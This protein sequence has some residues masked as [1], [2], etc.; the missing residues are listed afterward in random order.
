MGWKDEYPFEFIIN[1]TTVRDFGPDVDM[2]DNPY[3][4]DAIETD[5][6]ELVTMAKTRFTYIYNVQDHWEHQ[7]TLEEILPSGEAPVYPVCT[8]G[9]RGCP[10]DDC[11]GISRY[12]EMLNALADEKHPEHNTIKRQFGEREDVALFNIEE[13]NTSLR[14]Y[15]EEWDE[16]YSETGE[17]DEDL[18]DENDDAELDGVEDSEY[19]RLKH[20]KSPQDLL[21]DEREKQAMED[22]VDDALAETTSVEYQ[23][24]SRLVNLGHNEE[25]SKVMII[26][27]FSIERFYD[28]K[29]GTDHFD[30]RYEYNLGQ[31]PETPQEIPSLDYAVEVL[32]Q[33]IKG[34]PFAA[35]EYLHNDT[36]REAT[37][38]IVK[39]LKNF[40]DHQYCWAD[41]TSTPIWYALSAE[42]HLC[43]ELID[44]VIGFYGNGN[45]NETD[46]LYEQGQYLIGR[47]AQ[48]YPD[49]T[50][51]KVL[52]AMEKD[53]GNGSKDATYFLFDVFKFCNLDK[54]K[55]RLIALLKQDNISWHDTLAATIAHLQIKEGLP[56]L[57]EQ[58]K[59]LKAKKPEKSFWDNQ[60]IIEIEEAIQQL[61]KG[62]DLYP[63]IDM[64]L[65]LKRGTTWKEE[66]AN[67]EKHFYDNEHF[68]ED[69]VDLKTP[70]Y[71]DPYPEF[72]R[73]LTYQQPIIKENK[74]G[75]ND[76]C[77]CGSGKKYKKCCLDKDLREE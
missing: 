74:T 29:Y 35:I 38:A 62:E 31:L 5:L 52:A 71:F 63:D 55:D 22:W 67:A 57:K 23:T 46:W 9:E 15:S 25:K 1:E 64:P 44:P 50:V 76:P 20:L 26:E 32:D 39:A 37:V 4:R 8:G 14:R 77:P 6:D 17:D 41:C 48:K 21:N 53:A 28:L 51:Q 11:G 16:I 13:V 45:Q 30:D 70:D 42:G 60:H 56:V 72:A 68:E 58:L 47:L 75:R 43:E 59:R 54:Y 66:F 12:H 36:S 7:I 61:E 18:N 24:L 27:A 65:C 10:P 3:D 19:E 73:G 69:D 49:I 40:S 34:I 2:G 33:C